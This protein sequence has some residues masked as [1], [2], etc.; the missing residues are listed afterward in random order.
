MKV[1]LFVCT[2]FP[3]FVFSQSPEVEGL[4]KRKAELEEQILVL[5]EEL[6]SVK[7]QITFI[8]SQEIL[9]N[10]KEKPVLA[11]AK[12][13]A[14]LRDK[15]GVYGDVI[16]QLQEETPVQVLDLIDGYY[17]VCIDNKCGYISEIWI[18]TG[19]AVTN[20]RKAVKRRD[21]S[22]ALAAQAR[23]KEQARLASAKE[24]EARKAEEQRMLN[25]Y[26]KEQYN[27]MKDGY[28]WIGMNKEMLL[29]AIG[30]PEDINKTVGAWGTH[31]QW[32]YD[33]GLYIY[34]ENGKVTSYQK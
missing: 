30:S 24:Q 31:E 7:N 14:N 28:F 15:A 11:I 32:V 17:Q 5:Q 20:F 27:K 13:G 19:E 29:F 9:D 23:K 6:K 21:E 4:E 26:G 1:L 3:L 18:K 8:S 12:R 34:L 2:L 25:K 22:L 16:D 10:V 33:S